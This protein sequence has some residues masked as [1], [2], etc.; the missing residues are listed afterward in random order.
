MATVYVL[1]EVGTDFLFITRLS[2]CVI[3]RLFN[4]LVSVL[5]LIHSFSSLSYSRSKASFKVSSPLS[6]I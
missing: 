3:I 1:Y 2:P 5:V 4:A 6:A